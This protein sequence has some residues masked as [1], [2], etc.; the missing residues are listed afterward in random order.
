M[1]M[2]AADQPATRTA[3][4]LIIDDEPL[5]LRL[6]AAVLSSAGH[7][8]YQ[9]ANG[10]SGET[11]FDQVKPELTILDIWMPEQDGLQTIRQLRARWPDAKIMVMSG[12][13]RRAGMPVFEV[14][15]ILGAANLLAKPFTPEELLASVDAALAA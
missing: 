15:S 1:F 14:A 4:I 10:K 5:V 2:Q 7:T 6:A 13:P 3:R 9:A 11:I 12:Q 8:I